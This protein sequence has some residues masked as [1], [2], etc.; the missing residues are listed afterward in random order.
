[1]KAVNG[2]SDQEIADSQLPRRHFLISLLA[3][4]L[5]PP[6]AAMAQLQSKL[7]ESHLPVRVSTLN[8]V[9][10]GCNDLRSTVEWYGRVF[11]MAVHAFQDYG[12]GQTVVRIGDGPA[13][14]AL[15]QRNPKSIGQP[16]SRLPHFCWGVEDFNVDRILRALSEMQAPAQAVLRE[17]KTINGV[18]FDDPDGFPLQFN[19][20]NACGGGGFLGDVCDVSA[21][22]ARVPGGPPPIPVR[23]LNHVRLIVPNVQRTLDWYLRLTD[24]RRQ[25]GQE[26]AGGPRTPG[27]EGPPIPILR[28]GSGPQFVALVEG[29]GPAAFQPHI[30]FGVQGFDPDHIKERLAQHDVRARTTLREGTTVEILVDAPD[31]V[32]IQLQDVRYCGGRGPLGNMCG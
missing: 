3:A 29:S 5:W 24:M 4:G 18:N 11:G 17:G 14:M 28:V 7:K 25:T 15:S 2:R 27:Y 19:P 1:M 26:R 8:H 16:A 21:Q 12:G 10:F 20:V 31:G 23:T 13:Y 9:S 30:G 6:R 22:A 32:E